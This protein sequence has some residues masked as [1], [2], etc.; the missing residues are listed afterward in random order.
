MI[1]RADVASVCV[2]A[3]LNP[4]AYKVTFELQ[5]NN[6]KPPGPMNL[7]TLFDHLQPDTYEPVLQSSTE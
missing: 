3:V 7:D 2:A 4:K 6:K 5:S 1:A